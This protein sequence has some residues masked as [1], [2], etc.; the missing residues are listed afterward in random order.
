MKN[1]RVIILTGANSGIGLAM[2]KALAEKGDRVAC[3][4]L[5]GDRLNGMHYVPCDVTDPDGVKESVSSVLSEWGRIDILV[6]NACLALFSPFSG[7][8]MDETRRELEVNYFGYLNMIRAV[9]PAMQERQRGIIHNVSSTV[10][11]AG[12]SGLS[13]YV[14]AKGA[15]EALSRTLA[16]ELR[17]DGITVNL[18]HPPLTRTRSSAPI[19]IPESFMAEPEV[20]GRRLA[21]KIG[22]TKPIITAGLADSVGVWA[23]RLAP[24]FMGSFLSSRAA[25]AKKV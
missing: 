1:E 13:G 7:K 5:E 10:G 9:L 2:A 24:G 6:N 22:S 25:K 11:I 20:V 23:S 12:F 3:F 19:G 15:I 8:S 14:S 18:I 17:P 16:I 21:A 4:D